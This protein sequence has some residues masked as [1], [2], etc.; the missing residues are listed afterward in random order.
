[1]VIFAK[2][3]KNR[4]CEGVF[5]VQTS[6]Q[7]TT[8][9]K[10]CTF[11]S[12]FVK[13]GMPLNKN[14]KKAK[15]N[16]LHPPPRRGVKTSDGIKKWS[17]R[18]KTLSEKGRVSSE[19]N[20]KKRGVQKSGIFGFPFFDFL[21]PLASKISGISEIGISET[22]N[23]VFSEKTDILDQFPEN[24]KNRRFLTFFDDF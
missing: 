11:F 12:V 10:M 6:P 2:I 13:I 22:Q 8:F 4:I 21:A 18:E 14:A 15:K 7:D 20:G 23:P 24:A 5:F 17:I 16:T 9:P 1:M 3:A 19:M